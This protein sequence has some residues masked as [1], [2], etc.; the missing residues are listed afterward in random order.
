M[1]QADDLL[2]SIPVLAGSDL[3]LQQSSKDKS[4]GDLTFSAP[5]K[6]PQL[7]PHQFVCHLDSS[8]LA[9]KD[10]ELPQFVYGYIEC[11]FQSSPSVHHKML[12]HLSHLMDLAACF[13]WGA[14]RSF[15]ARVLKV[16]E[17]GVATWESDLQ[18][19]QT[20]LLL[21]SQKLPARGSS[22][23][24]ASNK[25][26]SVN[27]ESVCKDWNFTSCHTPCSS[28]HL[29]LCFTCKVPDHTA[30]ACPKHCCSPTCTW[31]HN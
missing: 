14:V 19:Y 3:N 28:D 8:N 26:P 16:M 6:L 1:Q 29:H 7:W 23:S 4:P 22:L 24:F 9:Y 11:L 13:Q 12:L 20:G 31:N 27:K 5:V 21:P 10:I 2:S 25:R 17:Q 30:P 15:H 18:H